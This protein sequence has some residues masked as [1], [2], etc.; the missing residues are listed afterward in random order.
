VGVFSCCV[1]ETADALPGSFD[2]A[3]GVVKIHHRSVG[4]RW[5]SLSGPEDLPGVGDL[6]G[7]FGWFDTLCL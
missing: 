7:P 6:L 3:Y 2:A 1:C 5:K 4:E